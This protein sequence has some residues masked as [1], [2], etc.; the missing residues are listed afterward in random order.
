M[1]KAKKENMCKC[2]KNP[3]T[4]PHTCPYNDEIHPENKELCT[5]CELCQH[6]CAM[7]V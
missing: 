1:K 7:D 6:E 3:A 5:C 2:G 4:E